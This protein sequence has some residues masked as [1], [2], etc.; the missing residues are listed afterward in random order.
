MKCAD[1]PELDYSHCPENAPAKMRDVCC[2]STLTTVG[3][4]VRFSVLSEGEYLEIG[5]AYSKPIDLKGNRHE[6]RKAA[7]RPR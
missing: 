7:K 2:T 4:D 3:T 5:K 6:R 1:C